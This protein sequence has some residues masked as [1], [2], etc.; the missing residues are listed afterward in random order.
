MRLHLIILSTL[1]L[2][3]QLSAQKTCGYSQI[4]NRTLKFSL[5]PPINPD[6]AALFQYK[7]SSEYTDETIFLQV[8]G[9]NPSTGAQCFISYDQDGNPSYFDV[10]SSCDSQNFSYPLSYFPNSSTSSERSI[11]LPMLAG[12][13]L[14]TSI[15]EKMT[16]EVIQNAQG[17]WTICAPNPFNTSDPNINILWDKT[18]FTVDSNTVFINPTAVDDFSLP[19]H[20]QETGK[21][22]SSQEGGLSVSRSEVFKIAQDE[23]TSA[24]SIWPKL[25][26]LKP[27]M[28]FSP[29]YASA[30]GLIPT[31]FLE[32]SGW[33]DGFLKLFSKSAM[34]IDVSESFPIS[35]GGGIWEG[36]VDPT[37]R[38]ITFN[39][40][41]DNDHPKVDPVYL[42]V[43]VNSQEIITGAGPSWQISSA[44]QAALARNLSCA[45]DTNTLS[46]QE[47]L[48]QTY[49]VKNKDNFYKINAALPENVQFID[50]YSKV[51]H[52]FGDH[53][54]YT[55]PYDDELNQSGAASYSKDNFLSGLIELFKIGS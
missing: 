49:F 3:T 20:V 48:C 36:L 19:I 13:R 50:H 10:T 5:L 35:E 17:V 31:Q 51:L 45:I 21:D 23:F 1:I 25:I 26:S 22:G 32:E 41:I 53:K 46:L 16:F 12:A 15:E 14:Y 43:P 28:I 38:I 52:S 18:E 8:V 42:T 40:Q 39:R 47:P 6:G 54:I 30:S 44:L 34:L 27:S 29:M 4:K 33:L 9:T 7:N 11:Y 2:T 24:G 55:L 37:T